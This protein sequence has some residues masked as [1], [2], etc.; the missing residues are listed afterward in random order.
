VR[1]ATALLV[2]VAALAV[3]ALTIGSITGWLAVQTVPTGSMEPAIARGSAILVDP[4]LVGDVAVGDVIVFAAPTTDTMTVHRVVEI[5]QGDL[6]PL[7]IT[8]GDANQG[9]DPWRLSVDGERVHR[10]RITVP[11]LGRVLLA[12][13]APSTRLLLA[14]AGAL[15]VLGFGVTHVWRRHPDE[16]DEPT[17]ARS[18]WDGALGRLTDPTRRHHHLDPLVALLHHVEHHPAPDPPLSTPTSD[19]TDEPTAEPPAAEPPTAEPPTDAGHDAASPRR[20]RTSRATTT[21]LAVAVLATGALAWNP[22][23][24]ADASYVAATSASTAVATAVVAPKGDVTCAW[25]SATALTVSWTNPVATD[26]ARVLVAAAPGGATAVAATAAAG[27]TSVP[28]AP[29]APLTTVRQL[30]TTAVRGTWTSTTSPEMATN[31]CRGAV[32]AFAGSGTRGSTGDGGSAAAAALDSPYQPYEAPDGRVF[33]ADSGNNRIRVVSPTGTISTFAG[34]TG[35]A[36]P[37]TYT[38]PVAGLRLNAPRGVA[39]DGA[40][41][42]YIAD[43]GR[44]CIRRVDATGNV[45]LFAGGGATTT[46]NTSVAPTNLSLSSPS[47]LALDATGGL[48]VA[49]TGRNC[50]RRLTATTTAIVAG[51]GGTTACASTTTATAVSLSGPMSVAVDAAGAVYI[52]DTGRSCVRKVVGTAVSR[53]AGGG[54]VTSCTTASTPA[55][56][57]LSNPQGVAVASDGS[58]HVADTGRR[59]LRTVTTTTVS[60]LALTGTNSSTGDDGPALAAT[61]RAPAMVATASDGDL[62]FSDRA[63]NSGANDVRRIELG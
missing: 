28:Y 42:V 15:F 2:G 34:G 18:T 35:G 1:W 31:T 11:V 44:G 6:G 56:V 33:I 13:S 12:L 23:P 62:L 17:D 46:C 5:E 37:C 54:S 29:A 61:A 52:A 32:R 60:P 4:V 27:A 39:V 30:S 47:G 57:S 7:F 45:T 21:A 50:V 48:I 58:V 10:V 19:T 22:L 24:R 59:C 49:D 20:R 36:S 51:G 3:L 63:T 43:T 40:G 25:T 26:T 55:T 16:H 41:T 38:G 9:P 8:K 53:V 14:G